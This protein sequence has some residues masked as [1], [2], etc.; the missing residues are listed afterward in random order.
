MMKFTLPLFLL[1]HTNVI[2]GD[3]CEP[4]CECNNEPLIAVQ[5][6]NANLQVRLLFFSFR[7]DDFY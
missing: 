6:L 4:S 7:T 3:Y 5:C 2:L 1:L